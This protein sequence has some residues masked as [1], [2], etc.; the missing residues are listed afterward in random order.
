MPSQR[1]Q[2]TLAI[3]LV[4]AT[5]TSA[6]A[7][8]RRRPAAPV[9]V[10]GP[11]RPGPGEGRVE[12][13][14]EK[15]AYLDHGTDAGL[16]AGQ[17]VALS[18]GGRPAGTCTVEVSAAHRAS[19]TGARARVGDTFKLGRPIRPAR[20]AA[21]AL[22]PVVEAEELRDDARLIADAEVAKVDFAGTSTF[23]ARQ[24]V[25]LDAGY[26]SWSPGSDPQGRFRQ[27]RVDGT[28]HVRFGQSGLRLDAAFSAVRWSLRPD[29]PRFRPA[30]PNQF[31]LWEAEVVHRDGDARTVAAVG[32]LWPWH[33]PGLGVL[34]G[35]QLGRHSADH[36]REWGGYAGLLPDALTLAPTT[37]FW[38]AGL[39]AGLSQAGAKGELFRL[40]REEAR[41]GVRHLADVGLV[42]EAE[43]LAQTWLGWWTIGAGG[44]AVVVPSVEGRPALD[45]AFLD[46]RAQPNFAASAGLHL[47]YFGASLDATESFLRNVTPSL[48]GRYHAGGDAHWDPIPWIGLGLAGDLSHDRASGF[49]ER[50]GAAELRLPRLLGSLGG[51]SVG[52]ELADGWLQTRAV[53]GQLLAHVFDRVRL[54]AR[55]SA[56][57]SEFAV[58]ATNPNTE[59]LD[60][61]LQLDAS[62]A[63][64]LQLRARALARTPLVVG[65]ATNTGLGLV[66][67]LGATGRF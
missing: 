47:R 33:T 12:F 30:Q 14:T 15:R 28:L 26:A 59:E 18:R 23:G 54:L 62:V 66:L 64:F 19:C 17:A 37:D 25:S 65:E 45:R 43:L 13:V 56:V 67:G 7:R 41:L 16:A 8:A 10:A 38:A 61:F 42:G 39:Y 11:A 32:R 63:S 22:P 35:V 46:V 3:A 51:V 20:V 31:Y 53:Y 58:P 55:V 6:A 34:D 57:G 49:A 24:A 36:T 48:Q 21:A 1:R 2:V 27:E 29:E 5:E 40:A 9:P 52:G 4:L 60:T 44:R 50:D